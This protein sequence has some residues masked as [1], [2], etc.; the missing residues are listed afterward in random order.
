MGA[1]DLHLVTDWTLTAPVEAVW[2]EIAAPEQW[3]SWWRAVMKVEM[4]ERG[5]AAGVGALRNIT[6]RTA[7]P[8]T[9]TFVIR[10][11][12]VE[13]LRSIEGRAE[14]E[15]DGTGLWT[16]TRSGDR[17]HVRYDWRV[18][19]TRPWMRIAA[20]LLRPVFAWNHGVV[21]GWGRDDLAKRL[22]RG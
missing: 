3:P 12:R 1:T 7:L 20:P 19:V 21:M 16:F 4:L 11:T 8:Y 22:A 14:G 5:D 13:P 18:A 9:L 6:W 10:T 2:R 15:L 17:T